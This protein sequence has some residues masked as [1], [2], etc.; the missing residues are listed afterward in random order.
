MHRHRR[1]R[2]VIGGLILAPALGTTAAAQSGLVRTDDGKALA[3]ATVTAVTLGYDVVGLESYGGGQVLTTTTDARGTFHVTSARSVTVLVRHG[4]GL[5]ALI[6]RL[7][8]GDATRVV[9][10]PLA[11]VALPPGVDGAVVH[12]DL[13]DG[14]QAA[15]G[16]QAGPKLELPAGTYRLVVGD[17]GAAGEPSEYS[18]ALRSGERVQLFAHTATPRRAPLPSHPRRTVKVIADGPGAHVAT[19]LPADRPRCLACSPV[20]P[21]GTVAVPDVAGAIHVVLGDSI[22]AFAGDA[23][24]LACTG[25]ST[26]RVRVLDAAGPV[27]DVAVELSGPLPQVLRRAYVDARGVATF[28]GVPKSA[29]TLE[30][31]ARSHWALPV[32]VTAAQLNEGLVTLH[33]ERGAALEGRIL[34]AGRDATEPA[35]ITVTLRDTS[36]ALRMRARQQSPSA[37]GRFAFPGLDPT[38]RYTLFATVDVAGVTHSAKVHGVLP[39]TP[40]VLDLLSEDVP[41]PGR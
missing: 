28:A 19:L 3:G 20:A 35:A 5:G 12:V 18:V 7:H 33:A 21:D 40:V 23:Q 30:L 37:A 38:G 39:G 16:R 1:R 13:G 34:V 26:L 32:A 15:F 11:E 10:T 31:H 14:A 17:G 24:Q 8:T 6:P 41:P 4:R 22:E 27:G 9:A 36:G 29:A 25:G 2:A